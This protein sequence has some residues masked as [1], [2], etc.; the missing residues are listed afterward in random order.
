MG[1]WISPD[2]EVKSI[3]DHFSYLVDHP[4]IIGATKREARKWGVAQ[5]RPVIEAALERGWV[6][7]LGS[8]P[9]LGI[10]FWVLTQS[11]IWQIK[12]FFRLAKMDPD[13]QVLFEETTTGDGRYKPARWILEDEALAAARNPRRKGRGRRKA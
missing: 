10:E 12:E 6:R 3:S 13:E 5:R 7:V 8:R 11:V 1:Y 4:H 9:N 2:A